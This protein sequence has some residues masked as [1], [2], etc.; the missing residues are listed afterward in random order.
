VFSIWRN[1]VLSFT[2]KQIEV[3]T[4]FAN[5]AVIAIEN[6]RL[7]RE[8][9]ARNRDLTETLERE[10]APG[11]ILRAIATSPTNPGLVFEAI[12]ESALRLCGATIGAVNLSDGRRD[13]GTGGDARGRQGRLSALADA[14]AG[15]RSRPRTTL[16]ARGVASFLSTRTHSVP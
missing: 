1:Q 10:T 8:L 5:Q 6:M 15:R 4:T 13:Q 3:V 7:F 14:V 11:G 9:E 12:P 2:D 16:T